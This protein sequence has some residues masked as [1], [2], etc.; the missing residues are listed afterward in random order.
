MIRIYLIAGLVFSIIAGLGY[1]RYSYVVDKLELTQQKLANETQAKQDAI[2]LNE[3]T[4]TALDEERVRSAKFSD[5]KE[6]IAIEKAERDRCIA[7]KSCG[8]IVQTKYIEMPAGSGV[9][10]NQAE[11]GADETAC[12]FNENFQRSLSELRASI[13]NDANQIIALQEDVLV[14]SKPDYCK[15]Q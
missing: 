5:E 10:T 15:V 1:W 12:Q 2:K 13:E 8:F 14:R 11:S 6:A 9:Q 3:K 7:N 4:Q